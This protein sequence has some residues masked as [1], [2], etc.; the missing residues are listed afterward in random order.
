MTTDTSVVLVMATI[1]MMA[2]RMTMNPT[3]TGRTPA[4]TTSRRAASEPP[5]SLIGTTSAAVIATST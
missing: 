5:S 2:N 4:R 3:G 1:A